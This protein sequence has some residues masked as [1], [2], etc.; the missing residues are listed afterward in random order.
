MKTD[1]YESPGLSACVVIN[2]IPY[3]RNCEAMTS[4]KVAEAVAR[5]EIK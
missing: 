4:P 1:N 3:Y 2:G 5:Y